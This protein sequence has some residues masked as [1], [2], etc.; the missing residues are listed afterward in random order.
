MS[1]DFRQS[2]S[3]FRRM[4]VWLVFCCRKIVYKYA[5]ISSKPMLCILSQN[6]GVLLLVVLYRNA[7]AALGDGRQ[8]TG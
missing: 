3:E 6:D 1:S 4:N 2:V 8:E 5:T 7:A